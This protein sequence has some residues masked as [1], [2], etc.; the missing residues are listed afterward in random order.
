MVI[1][2]PLEEKPIL[3]TAHDDDFEPIAED[4]IDGLFED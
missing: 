1:E 4:E 3:L 2:N